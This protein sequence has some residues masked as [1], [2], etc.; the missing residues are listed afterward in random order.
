MA[1]GSAV[2]LEPPPAGA[3]PVPTVSEAAGAP[4][5]LSGQTALIVI[6]PAERS[7]RVSVIQRLATVSDHVV[8][9]T[10]QDR[11]ALPLPEISPHPVQAQ[12]VEF[13]GGWRSPREANGVITDAVPALFTTGE[14]AYAFVFQPSAATAALRWTM[15]YGAADV[16]LLAPEHGIRVSGARLRGGD[17]VTERGRP[18]RRWS[19]GPIG[20]GEAFAVRLDGLPAPEGRWPEVVAG[21]FAVVLISALVMALRRRPMPPQPGREPA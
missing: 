20:P 12:P 14:M 16:E 17:V 2:V 8:L 4:L 7:L 6:E 19:A 11:L 13:V 21:L 9:G 5:P 1:A 3:N 10:K 18:Y 15:P